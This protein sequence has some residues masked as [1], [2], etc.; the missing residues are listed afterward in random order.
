[1]LYLFTT[2]S[3]IPSDTVSQTGDKVEPADIAAALSFIKLDKIK[4]N[5]ALAK[6]CQDDIA[7]KIFWNLLTKNIYSDIEKNNWSGDIT[8]AESLAFIV[9]YELF[10]SKN[11]P[12]CFETIE[13]N[14]TS[15]NCKR[16]RGTKKLAISTRQQEKFTGIPKSTWSRT[17]RK[18]VD[19]Y[20]CDIQATDNEISTCLKRQLYIR[21]Q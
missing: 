7:K 8:L 21:L 20:I 3:A 17:W 5:Y 10:Y 12:Q 13:E 11:C 15:S 18:R 16:C 14:H 1:M 2:K 4:Y 6:Y 19:K 9:T